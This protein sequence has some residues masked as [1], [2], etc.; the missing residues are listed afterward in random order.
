MQALQRVILVFALCCCMVEQ[1][2]LAPQILFLRLLSF[3][4][5]L[6]GTDELSMGM[7][8]AASSPKPR[9]VLMAKM[10]P[11]GHLAVPSS[12]ELFENYFQTNLLVLRDSSGSEKLEKE[13]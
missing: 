5:R 8:R 10:A 1:G 4:E 11:C 12:K 2:I 7:S 6:T 3:R 9:L 13:L